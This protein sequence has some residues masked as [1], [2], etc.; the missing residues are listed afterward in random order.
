MAT[1]SKVKLSGSTN[2]RGILVAATA[3]V[4]T[5]IHATGISAT[6]F[7]EIWLYVTNNDTV[8][9][10]LTIEFGGTTN[11]NDVIV[12]AVPPKS[13]LTLI[14]PGLVLSGTG[15]VVT[16]I[17]AFASTANKLVITGYVNRIA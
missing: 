12:L 2:G 7:D 11:P 3:T 10:T 6:V 17:T 8:V 5:T 9:V 1:F 15:S 14:I 4:G 16:T 13:G